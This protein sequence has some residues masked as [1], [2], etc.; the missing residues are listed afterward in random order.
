MNEEKD[1]DLIELVEDARDA[2][3]LRRWKVAI[4][5]DDPAVHEGTRYALS[6]YQL[7]GYGLTLLS[8][9]S[10][11]EGRDLL[12]REK[13]IA[14]ILL[15]VVMETETAGLSLVGYIRQELGNEIV[16][17]ILRTGQPGQAPERNVIVD[18]DI[19][20]YKAKTE[21]TADK[22]FTCVTAALRSHQQLVRVSETRRGL[23]I[24]LE[25][26]SALFDF[27]SMQKLAEGV[28]TQL[29]SL[30]DVDCA[31]IL[32]L[33]ENDH[34]DFFVLAGSGCYREL[35]G[36]EEP[37]KLTAQL[38]AFIQNAFTRRQTE[39]LEDRSVLYLSTASGTEVVVLLEAGKH[40][41]DTD[42]ALVEIFCSRLTVAFDNVVL[43]EQLQQANARLE[44]RVVERTRELTAANARLRAQWIRARRTNAFQSEILGTVAHD[45]RNPLSVILGRAE[46]MKEFLQEPNVPTEKMNLQLEHVRNAASRL[47]DMVDALITEALADAMDITL[48]RES[49]DFV[50][51]VRDVLDANLPLAQ[52]KGQLIEI[53]GASPARVHS[54]PDRLREAVDNLISNAIKYTPTGGRIDVSV[55]EAD[56]QAVLRVRDN[57]P[58]LRPEDTRRLF[59]RFQ[60]LSAKP[61]GGEAST[62]L[63][64]SIAKKIVDLHDGEIFAESDGAGRGSTFVIQLPLEGNARP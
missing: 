34:E 26:A 3:P 12:A 62:G 31:G 40:L 6:D 37:G 39:F 48:R 55:G 60:R 19:N 54:D 23:E 7:N 5:D 32:V 14:V 18:Y 59:G 63:G 51:L 13:D 41:S 17:I 20:D 36:L 49:I 38:R 24:I 43:Y 44:K 50:S 52:R 1:D 64:L 10:A 27:K 35:S 28:L 58:G 9:H 2:A 33:R 4:I 46:M 22:L 15:D 30:L 25:A 61:T 16:R 53:D 45:I 56:G 29:S 57:G 8:A 11:Q 42:R 21:L 47:S